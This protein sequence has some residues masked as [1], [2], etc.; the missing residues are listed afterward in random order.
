MQWRVSN[1]VVDFACSSTLVCFL[2]CFLL[3]FL[4][5]LFL[6]CCILVL[7]SLLRNVP[8]CI[9]I[10]RSQHSVAWHLCNCKYLLLIDCVFLGLTYLSLSEK[11]WKINEFFENFEAFVGALNTM[12]VTQHYI[13]NACMQGLLMDRYTLRMINDPYVLTFKEFSVDEFCM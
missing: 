10:K 13:D 9:G 4:V 8:Q 2:A 12:C 7:L 3:T 1:V 5:V 6:C 11:L